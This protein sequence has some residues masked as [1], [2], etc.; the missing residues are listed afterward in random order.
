MI[1]IVFIIYIRQFISLRI[2]ISVKYTNKTI[3]K[4]EKPFVHFY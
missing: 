4:S 3:Q 2:A 1:D